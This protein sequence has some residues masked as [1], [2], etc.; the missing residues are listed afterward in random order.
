MAL[1]CKNHSSKLAGKV[2]ET[3]MERAKWLNKQTVSNMETVMSEGGEESRQ[4]NYYPFS[5]S[6]V[7]EKEMNE[8]VCCNGCPKIDTL[9]KSIL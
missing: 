8:T 9:Q 3:F 6:N 4:V 5:I 7:F 2:S 1:Y